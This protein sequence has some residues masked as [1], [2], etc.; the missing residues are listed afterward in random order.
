MGRGVAT[1]YVAVI[2]DQSLIRRTSTTTAA[3]AAGA[4]FLAAALAGEVPQSVVSVRPARLF[5]CELN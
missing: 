4:T 2:L 3:A 5:S 1:N